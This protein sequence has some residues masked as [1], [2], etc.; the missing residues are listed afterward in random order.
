MR[1]LDV[2]HMLKYVMKF[3]SLSCEVNLSSGF[4]KFQKF[5]KITLSIKNL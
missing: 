5:M 4:M 3:L 1:D 2:L